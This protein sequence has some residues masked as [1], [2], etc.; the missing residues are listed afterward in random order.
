MSSFYPATQMKKADV[1]KLALVAITFVAFIYLS[2]PDRGGIRRAERL[3]ELP[4]LGKYTTGRESLWIWD[5][6]ESPRF[7]FRMPSSRFEEFIAYTTASGFQKWEPGDGQFGS[8]NEYS[9]DDNPLLYTK[10]RVGRE[11]LCLFYYRPK[12]EV[13]NVI[14]FDLR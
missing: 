2:K 5:A 4:S 7:R 6:F 13:L 10:K 14:V 8:F 12:A 1:V 9:T 11:H 3:S